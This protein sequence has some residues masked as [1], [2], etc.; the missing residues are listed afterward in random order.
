LVFVFAQRSRTPSHPFRKQQAEASGASAAAFSRDKMNLST[1]A[2]YFFPNQM[3]TQ[4][5]M[6][7]TLSAYRRIALPLLRCGGGGTPL[8]A[9]GRAPLVNQFLS[10][11]PQF[12]TMA[13]LHSGAPHLAATM[14]REYDQEI[15]DMATYIH[16]YK[17]DSNLAVSRF[18]VIYLQSPGGQFVLHRSSLTLLATSS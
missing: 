15:N 2:Q 18:I 10:S 14:Q 1:R 5:A 13:P 7:R 3:T 4:S 9:R 8:V 12:T 17:V 6:S 16:K 11:Q